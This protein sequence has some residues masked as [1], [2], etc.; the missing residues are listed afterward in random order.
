[1][2][3]NPL[4]AAFKKARIARKHIPA[5]D[6]NEKETD[7]EHSHSYSMSCPQCNASISF[8]EE[9]LER[10]RTDESAGSTDGE[11][12]SGPDDDDD[13]EADDPEDRRS[14][15]VARI[16]KAANA[17]VVAVTLEVPLQGGSYRRSR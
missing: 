16:I 3:E 5:N 4:E 2:P 6:A 15:L 14:A 10:W 17:Q 11:D 9:D 7:T 13:D 8:A 1:M 12:D